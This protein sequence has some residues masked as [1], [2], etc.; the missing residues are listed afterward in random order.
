M[1]SFASRVH[2]VPV[3]DRFAPIYDLVSP[4]TDAKPLEDGLA[5]A[6]RQVEDVI[7]LGGGTGRAARALDRD[8][9][10]VDA[11]S[12]MLAKANGKGLRTVRS[13]VRTLPFDDESVDAVVSVDAIH[14]FP[15]PPAVVEEVY[16]VL[17]VGGVFVAREFD[18]TTLRGMA[19]R[20][21]QHVVGFDCTLYPPDELQSVFERAG[22]ET[23]VLDR[24]F[25]YTVVGVKP[26][27]R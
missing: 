27:K 12:G 1:P 24:G 7:D 20:V 11:S 3:F 6:Q 25:V 15:T 5:L 17:D 21:G 19:L 10:V 13:D 18:P 14:H 23:T 9:L 8:L 2:D 22:F 4:S 26:G 16:R